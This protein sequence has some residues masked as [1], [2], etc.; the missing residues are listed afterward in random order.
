MPSMFG[1]DD[2][3]AMRRLRLGFDPAGLANRASSCRRRGS[4]ARCR[5]LPGTPP[6]EE[7][8]LPS[9]FEAGALAIAQAAEILAQATREGRRV[10]I[11]RAGG[12]LVVSTRYL[13]RLLEH[14]AGTSRPPSRRACASRR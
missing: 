8:G 4:A 2:L 3:E 1:P 9:V 7:Q 10:S 12:D 6:R 11:D 5:A 13:N 14:E